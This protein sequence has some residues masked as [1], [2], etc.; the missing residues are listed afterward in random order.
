[1]ATHPALPVAS[2][3]RF[4][5]ERAPHLLSPPLSIP[6]ETTTMPPLSRAV[7][8]LIKKYDMQPH[9][10]GG[11]YK[12]TYRSEV[13]VETDKGIRSASTAIKFLVTK[14]SVS[15]LHRI[16]SDEVWHFYAGSPLTIVELDA[17]SQKS[18]QTKLTQLGS[19]D[20]DDPSCVQQYVVKGGTWF[21]SFP[22][23]G[24]EWCLVGCTVSPGFDFRDFEMA[25]PEELRAQFPDAL[26]IIEK[27]TIGL[28]KKEETKNVEEKKSKK[29]STT[30][31]ASSSSANELDIPLF[32][33]SKEKPR[34]I[35]LSLA[36]FCAI[37]FFGFSS[38][39]TELRSDQDAF[40]LATA[41]CLVAFEMFVFLQV[42]DLITVWPHPGFWR[43]V[44]GLAAFYA[45]IL[46]AMLM[47]DFT[48]ARWIF[49]SL[50]GDIGSW[51]SY[52]QKTEYVKENVMGSCHLDR[53]NVASV[54][55]KQIFGAPWFLSHA[56]GWLGKMMIFR[57][58]KVCLIAALFFEFT[59]MTLAYVCPE[60]EECWWDSIFLDTLGANLLGMWMG[61][62]VNRWM[63]SY[64]KNRSK[65][66]T[67]GGNFLQV[68]QTLG[69]KLDWAGKIDRSK[70]NTDKLA[71]MVNP[72]IYD[73][74]HKW[75]IFK[76]PLRLMQV[77]ILIAVMLFIETNTF[78]MMNAM[79]IPHDSWYNKARLA[80]FGFM[81]I[82]AAAEWY[83]YVEQTAKAGSDVARIGPACWLCFCVALLENALFWKFFPT[84]FGVE[85]E[86]LKDGWIPIP[87]DIMV[88]HGLAYALFGAW[89][90]LR[91]HVVGH[92][93]DDE[94]LNE[95]EKAVINKL[96]NDES[97]RDRRK[98]SILKSVPK[99]VMDRIWRIEAV[100]LLLYLSVVPL[101]GLGT[102]WKWD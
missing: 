4:L 75:T 8:S 100:D 47:L 11:Y 2:S 87:T 59:E 33:S 67:S 90:I 28:G 1:M 102:R 88:K 91:F 76:S 3:N 82:P 20:S 57:D 23:E 60:F 25:D 56:L 92:Q 93:V 7:R 83:V 46:V 18:N 45:L 80:L 99:D 72:L 89:F 94:E 85:L 78:L 62:H 77:A 21:G 5:I 42:R 101:L 31:T 61:T 15:R 13:E 68:A 69:T 41:F 24:S 43:L 70:K 19:S 10:E 14:E 12:E 29:S 27:M 48:R 35:M 34:Q 97:N 73:S 96:V 37:I 54:L 17:D 32:R 52:E 50:L 36:V 30:S 22:T 51:E 44:F 55:Y 86:K 66:T 63:E 49:E 81:S 26:G 95:D 71:S 64:S 58:W 74:T 6:Q 16:E 40:R 53:H 65:S 84:H 9:P 79:G 39:T 98:L 38:N